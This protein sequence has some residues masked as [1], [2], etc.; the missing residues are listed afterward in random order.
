MD[1]DANTSHMEEHLSGKINLRLCLVLLQEHFT[2][3]D[4]ATAYQENL[5]TVL[6][7]CHFAFWPPKIAIRSVTYP[8]A[9][10]IPINVF[11]L[12]L[13]ADYSSP[14]LQGVFSSET[15]FSEGESFFDHREGK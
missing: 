9:A 2:A 5:T 4:T 12:R 13:H 15:R 11:V 1:C 7:A 14:S 3:A 6:R 8:F 10:C